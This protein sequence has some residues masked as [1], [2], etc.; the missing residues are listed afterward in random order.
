MHMHVDKA[1]HHI[2]TRHIDSFG[3]GIGN[4]S[5]TCHHT[6]FNQHVGTDEFSVNIYLTSLEQ[7]LHDIIFYRMPFRHMMSLH[8]KGSPKKLPLNH[9]EQ[10]RD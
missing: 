4:L 6:V 10:K 7:L 1:R 3:I 9:R 5:E 8:K 2:F